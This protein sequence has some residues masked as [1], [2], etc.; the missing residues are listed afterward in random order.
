M[1]R[2]RVNPLALKDLQEIKAYITKELCNPDAAAGVIKKIISRYEQLVE[3]PMM[4][5]GLSTVL[6]VNT[7]YRY[8]VSGNYLIFY[9]VE[10]EH[11]SIYRILYGRRDYIRI[12]IGDLPPEK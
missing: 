9:R 2:I 5:T 4:G 8:L 12:L 11:V 6:N 1:Y 7:D 10:G 3:Y